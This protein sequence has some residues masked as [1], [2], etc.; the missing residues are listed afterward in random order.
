MQA[1]RIAAARS[2]ESNVVV[3]V[4]YTTDIKQ[5]LV[6]CNC[7]CGKYSPPLERAQ[8]F[9]LLEFKRN[10]MIKNLGKA[11]AIRLA[12]VNAYCL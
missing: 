12:I 11:Q 3:D 9:D 6:L 5:E 2:E 8:H 1:W 7:E 10:K 4:C